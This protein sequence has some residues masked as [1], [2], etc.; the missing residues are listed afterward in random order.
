[1]RIR[2]IMEILT[3]FFALGFAGVQLCGPVFLA[4]WPM[5]SVMQQRL[6]GLQ[7]IPG[8]LGSNPYGSFVAAAIV[9]LLLGCG[10]MAVLLLKSDLIRATAASVGFGVL[11]IVWQTAFLCFLL[12]AS[13]DYF[14][15]CLC[16]PIVPML[17]GLALVI[18]T[19]RTPETEPPKDLQGRWLTFLGFAAGAVLLAAAVV[20][21]HPFFARVDYS[22]A[23]L[24]LL[25]G[26]GAPAFTAA[27]VD[28]ERHPCFGGWGADDDFV[29]PII[30]PPIF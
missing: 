11:T 13:F 15:L 17:L 20:V 21:T 7:V 9:G 16:L 28:L 23:V 8:V 26:L 27:V 25:V 30:M 19:A 2:D 22:A 29:P 3:G 12:E 5:Y 24:G 18:H 6:I 14:W 1:M 4:M 10:L